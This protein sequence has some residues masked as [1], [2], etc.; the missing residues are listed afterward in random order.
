[1][2]VF[3]FTRGRGHGVSVEVRKQLKGAGFLL[4]HTMSFKIRTQVVRLVSKRL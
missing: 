2:G 1:M 3:I 4:S